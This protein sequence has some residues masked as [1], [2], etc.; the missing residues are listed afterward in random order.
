MPIEM[1]NVGFGNSVAVARVV[2]IARADSSP[3]RRLVENA[4]A[5]NRL[6]DATSGRKTR[7]L[8]VT[9]SHHVILSH[10]SP[11]TLRDKLIGRTEATAEEEED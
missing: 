6:V 2:A 3:L 4:A 8:V 10:Q 5:E 1:I 11:A 9:D 7:S